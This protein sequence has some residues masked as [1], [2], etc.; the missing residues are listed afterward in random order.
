[1]SDA[2]TGKKSTKADAKAVSV[3]PAVDVPGAKASRL[4]QE[5]VPSYSLSEALRVVRA[6]ADN[7]AYNPTRPLNVAGAMGISPTSSAFRMITGAAL[8]YGLTTGAAKAPEIGLT[9]VG[10][11][12]VRPTIEG[13]DLAAMREAL[14][15]PRVVGEFLR[16]Y[17]GA[18]LPSDDIAKNVLQQ[19]GVPTDRTESVLALIIAGAS[20]VG[21]IKEYSGKRFVDLTATGSGDGTPNASG[22]AVAPAPIAAPAYAP[23]AQ[24]LLPGAAPGVSVSAGVNINIEIHIAADA[25]SETIEDIFK[26]MHR[27]VLKPDIDP[28]NV[29]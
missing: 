17:D 23:S 6:I 10:L 22:V 29:E 24:T 7:Y 5:D 3:A 1:M 19:K 27:Y 25:S 11:R 18:A 26:N 8:A 21:F 9:P 2:S 4:S 20:E 13:D 12:I 16:E 15:K 28:E 14:L